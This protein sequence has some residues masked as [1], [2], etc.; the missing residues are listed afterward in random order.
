MVNEK[1]SKYSIIGVLAYMSF[2][3]N[4]VYKKQLEEKSQNVSERVLI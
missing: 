4:K 2:V 3:K 1:K